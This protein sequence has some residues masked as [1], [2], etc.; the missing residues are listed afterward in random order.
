MKNTKLFLCAIIFALSGCG[1]GEGGSDSIEF[2]PNSLSFTGTENQSISSQTVKVNVDLGTT[3]RYVGVDNKN[4]ELANVTYKV[5]HIDAF[6][7][8]ITPVFGLKKGT[9][10][11]T[12]DALICDDANCRDVDDR[13][14]YKY[15]ITIN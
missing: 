1:G 12:V 14:E 3:Q 11:G 7:M 13:G 6:S 10:N 9:Y 2:S 5:T 8:T 15:T 4:P